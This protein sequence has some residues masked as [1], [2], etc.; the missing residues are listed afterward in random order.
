METDFVDF[1][2]DMGW[3]ASHLDGYHTSIAYEEVTREKIKDGHAAVLD[4]IFF[5]TFFDEPRYA[6]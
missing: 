4:Y 5:I 1:H 2:Y 6:G 3:R